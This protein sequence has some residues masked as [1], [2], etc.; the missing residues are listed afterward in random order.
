[1]SKEKLI[2]EITTSDQELMLKNLQFGLDI[3]GWYINT[4]KVT[5]ENLDMA[6]KAW[7]QD[8]TE[9]RA[10]DHIVANGLGILFGNYI[11]QHKQIRWVNIFNDFETELALLSPE[12]NEVYPISSVW[13]RI[14][15]ENEEM[16]FFEPIYT[17]VIDE[18]FRDKHS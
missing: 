8:Y 1:M 18:S 2:T 7:K 10:P 9:N 15:P 11:L 16:S 12:G 6:F 17:L 3:M 13:K 14:D 4:T 5:L